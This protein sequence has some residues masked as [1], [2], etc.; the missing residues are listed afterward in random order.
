MDLFLVVG[1]DR[2]EVLAERPSEW[3]D[4]T[5]GR[6]WSKHARTVASRASGG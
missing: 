5:S 3:I 6:L 4:L 1:G 2:R